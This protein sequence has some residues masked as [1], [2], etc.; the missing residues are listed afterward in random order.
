MEKKFSQADLIKR[1]SIAAILG[2][3]VG[4][5]AAYLLLARPDKKKEFDDLAMKLTGP[6]DL[7]LAHNSLEAYRAPDGM[8][9]LSRYWQGKINGIVHN[10]GDLT[11]IDS[12]FNLFKNSHTPFPDH[13]WVVGI[14]PNIVFSNNNTNKPRL[15]LYF[16]PTMKDTNSNT[17]LDYVEV[18]NS[19]DSNIYKLK[20]GGVWTDGDS[21]IYDQGTL[22]P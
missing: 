12:V 22:F 19:K 14:Y 8:S 20:T 16:I 3:L 11:S 7:T 4:L 15:N 9:N 6:V 10:S 18:R 17:Y 21:Y 5:F 13:E 2:I 1:I